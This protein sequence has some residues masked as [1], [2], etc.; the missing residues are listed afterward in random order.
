M[1]DTT[2]LSAAMQIIQS[3]Y[4]LRTFS[5]ELLMVSGSPRFMCSALW[6]KDLPA[7]SGHH[8]AVCFGDTLLEAI[9]ATI[10]ILRE[11]DRIHTA[12]LFADAA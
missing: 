9:R 8:G 5:L 4:H 10:E 3:R 2:E 6:D 7:V 12:T 11:R 1:I